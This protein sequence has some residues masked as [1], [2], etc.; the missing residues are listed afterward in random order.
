MQ[1]VVRKSK[2]SFK[3]VMTISTF[4]FEPVVKLLRVFWERMEG[5]L[6]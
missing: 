3:N 6:S 2:V 1:K 5:Y 4:D